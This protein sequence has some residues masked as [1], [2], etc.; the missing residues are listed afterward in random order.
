MVSRTMSGVK[1]LKLADMARKAPTR[2]ET[3]QPVQ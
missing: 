1:N 3:T 2:P